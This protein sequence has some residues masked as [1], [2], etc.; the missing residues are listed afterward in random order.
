M[1]YPQSF[2]QKLIYTN[3]SLSL[4][5]KLNVS[6]AIASMPKKPN[7]MITWSIRFQELVTSLQ[8]KLRL[9]C[10]ARFTE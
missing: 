7:S 5:A 8:R 9:L 4:P 10:Q 6:F 3:P 2:L 1:T